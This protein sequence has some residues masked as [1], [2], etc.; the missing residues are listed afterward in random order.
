MKA[1][2]TGP[3]ATALTFGQR[4]KKVVIWWGLPLV[5]LDL[6]H[7]LYQVS[8]HDLLQLSVHEWAVL[9]AIN[10]PGLVLGI[11]I[12][13][14]IEHTIARHSRRSGIKEPPTPTT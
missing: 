5:C 13:A 1:S 9:A 12:I 8:L 3:S 14:M 4:L 2:L 11:V 10:L 6:F 7:L